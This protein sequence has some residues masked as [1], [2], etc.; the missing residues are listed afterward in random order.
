MAHFKSCWIQYSLCLSSAFGLYQ[1]PREIS[2]F[3]VAKYFSVD[4]WVAD[5]LGAEHWAG[6]FVELTSIMNHNSKA[7]AWAA[8]Q[9]GETY[10]KAQRIQ[11]MIIWECVPTC[12]P[13]DTPSLIYLKSDL[14]ATFLFVFL[15]DST[16]A[17]FTPPHASCGSR[18]AW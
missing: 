5:C 1:L 17:S 9:W 15:F 6:G 12:D 11:V 7:W 14:C 4:R 8:K 2:G 16:S 3:L 13:S 18:D 10:C